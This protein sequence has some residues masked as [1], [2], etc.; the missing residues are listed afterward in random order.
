MFREEGLLFYFKYGKFKGAN[1]MIFPIL[2]FGVAIVCAYVFI[3][4][5]LLPGAIDEIE[6][7]LEEIVAGDE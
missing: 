3:K 4:K 7:P 5:V 6:L 1:K 2:L